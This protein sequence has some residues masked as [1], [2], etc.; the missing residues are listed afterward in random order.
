MDL[1]LSKY[2]SASV[3][4]SPVS[5]LMA[6]F[7]ADFREGVDID[8]GVGYVNEKTIPI[9][10]F[11]DAMQAVAADP[12]TYRQAFNYGGP[13]GAPNLI[14]A[15]RRFLAA[16]R[17]GGLDADTLARKRIVIGPCGATSFLEGLSEIFE[18]GIVVT[19]DPMYYI[20]A[21]ALERKGFEVLAVPE[22]SEGIELAALERKLA[23][24]GKRAS[25]IA[26]FYTVT[27]TRGAGRSTT[28][29]RAFRASRAAPYPS[30]TTSP[31]S[32]CCTTPQP[33]H[34]NPCWR[35]MSWESPTKSARCRKCSRPRCGWD[36]CSALRARSWTR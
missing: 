16:P 14:A 29:P 3:T 31:T 6:A 2:G 7:I 12:V 26:F 10:L 25:E 22:D 20:Y 19:S 21:N 36:I 5:R 34:F 11:A 13:H 24:L 23:A 33:S 35:R 15:L 28:W 32:C 17:H 18:P 27:R 9:P 8:L 4:P 1:R 30:F